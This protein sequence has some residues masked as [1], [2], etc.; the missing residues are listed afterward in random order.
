M[1]IGFADPFDPTLDSGELARRVGFV[2]IARFDTTTVWAAVK[3][4]TTH[5]C[6]TTS[7]RC[8]ETPEHPD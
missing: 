7:T 1:I 2:P 3:P 6:L 5:M 8:A 4:D